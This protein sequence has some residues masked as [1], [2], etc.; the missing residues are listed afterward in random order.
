MKYY[1]DNCEDIEEFNDYA[2]DSHCECG[3]HYHKLLIVKYEKDETVTECI[4]CKHRNL[5]IDTDYCEDC[6]YA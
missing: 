4:T 2:E 5:T 3:G 1:C 6:I